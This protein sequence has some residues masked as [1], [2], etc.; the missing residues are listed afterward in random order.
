MLDSVKLKEKLK[1][2]NFRVFDFLDRVREVNI[3]AEK[4]FGLSQFKFLSKIKCRDGIIVDSPNEWDG[5][6]WL[7]S[8][9]LHLQ[10]IKINDLDSLLGIKKLEELDQLILEDVEYQ[11]GFDTISNLKDLMKLD[12]KKTKIPEDIQFPQIGL[13][14]PE[15][16][17]SNCDQ[18]KKHE[19][20]ISNKA[21]KVF[22]TEYKDKGYQ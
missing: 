16:W 5:N 11:E 18:N 7:S 15:E 3:S 2:F 10:K 4:F 9:S 13:F 12:I 1:S 21:V 17:G 8:R 14:S 22:W 6:I 19:V 20:T